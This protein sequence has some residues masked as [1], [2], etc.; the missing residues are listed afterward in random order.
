MVTMKGGARRSVAVMLAEVEDL[1]GA[2]N[3]GVERRVVLKPV[4]P[5]PMK[6]K[7][8]DVKFPGLGGSKMRRT[9]VTD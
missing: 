8:V 3:L 6:A 9:G 4:L 5:V 7:V 1:A 2:R